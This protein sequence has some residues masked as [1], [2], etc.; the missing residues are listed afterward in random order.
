M[1]G[2]S[3]WFDRESGYALHRLGK[4]PVTDCCGAKPKPTDKGVREYLPGKGEVLLPL[5][6]C[7]SCGAYLLSMNEKWYKL[8]NLLKYRVVKCD[9]YSGSRID[10]PSDGGDGSGR[11]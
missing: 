10:P 9:E 3:D 6:R 5:Y 7:E 1:S 4:R 11:V 8:E 2:F